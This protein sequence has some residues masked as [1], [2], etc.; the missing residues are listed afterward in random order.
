[1]E[2]E[3]LEKTFSIAKEEYLELIHKDFP[4]FNPDEHIDKGSHLSK[5][6]KVKNSKNI[7][8]NLDVTGDGKVDVSDFIRM[9][10]A[11]VKGS[12][13]KAKH[14]SKKSNQALH[15]INPT[16]VVSDAK[17][18]ATKVGSSISNTELSDVTSTA[19]KIAKTA[20]G[21]QGIQ[22]RNIAKSILEVCGEYYDSAEAITEKKRDELNNNI[23]DFGE[24]R[25]F[26]L[27]RTVGPFLK[28]LE[29]LEQKNSVKEYEVL[30]GASIDTKT[31][32][33]I[34]KID[35]AASEALRTTA[36]SGA[37][38]A[39]AVLGTPS[40][41]TGTVTA[42]A[43]A[44]TG[45]AISSLS[46]AAANNAVLAWLGGGSLATGGEEWLRELLL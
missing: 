24:Y 4:G 27:H 13:S 31:L 28:Y 6:K 30:I 11:I 1:M 20:V 5:E 16:K 12:I 26:A 38:G 9:P 17:S 14:T 3:K 10:K 18:V 34:E 43:S 32:D 25:L 23:I 37:F 19:G 41:V 39:A 29:Q 21:A 8:S 36:V 33:K 46:G 22:N 15:S 44:S 45:T 42:F 40:L 35:M 2:M 7:L